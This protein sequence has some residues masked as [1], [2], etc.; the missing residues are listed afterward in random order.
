MRIFFFIILFF[1]DISVSFSQ[2]LTSMIQSSVQKLES[3]VQMKHAILALQVVETATG[4]ILYSRNAETGLSV[5]S[6]QKVFTAAAAFE[7]LGN[8]YRYSTG[9][10]ISPDGT[11]VLTGTGDPTL[12]S[13]RYKHTRDT[14]ILNKW[15]FALKSA[16]IT[17]LNRGIFINDHNSTESLGSP[18]PEG[19]IW[20]D[21]GN[22]YGAGTCLTNWHENQ[23]DVVFRSGATGTATSIISLSP[24][25]P[26]LKIAN[27]VTAGK[28]GSGDNAYIFAAPYSGIA[29]IKGTI[30]PSSNSF[31]ISGS[32]PNPAYALGTALRRAI[33]KAGITIDTNI[34]TSAS[35]SN[36]SAYQGKSTPVEGSRHY[37]PTLD[38]IIYWFLQKSINLYGEAL[39]KSFSL[40]A[41]GKYELDAGIGIMKNF[42]LK[43][44]IEKSAVNVFDG[45]GLSPSNRVTVASLVKVMLFARKRSW[46]H[47][48]YEAL[49]EY[50]GIKMK[51]GS[52]GGARS[53]TGYVK[54]RSGK[55]YTFA[56]V[57]NNYD[58]SASQ[59]VQKMYN[60][61]DILK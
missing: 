48:F 27:M 39:V 55:E 33:T 40:N 54:S 4:K 3:D 29:Y 9:L 10:S 24:A 37:S 38:S 43:Q 36:I 61:L 31:T 5:A 52:I 16:G 14:A 26:A 8:D 51:S 12:G 34:S 42:L 18:I 44:G 15:V 47:S 20:Q 56:I 25:P 21:I 11:L 7:L 35:R 46:Y 22:Y 2:S 23:Y 6:T 30:P 53:F 57:I 13:W 41:N 49:P 59:V 19:Y 50:N 58:G 1:V 17:N 32:L 45:S 28:A 60:L